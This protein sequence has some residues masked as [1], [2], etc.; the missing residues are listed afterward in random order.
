MYCVAL[1][2][3]YVFLVQFSI[4]FLLLLFLLFHFGKGFHIRKFLMGSETVQS[5]DRAPQ[6][7]VSVD[8]ELSWGEAY[9][10]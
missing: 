9:C 6:S 8:I 5:G 7:M 1:L 3:R 10:S 4:I 2:T